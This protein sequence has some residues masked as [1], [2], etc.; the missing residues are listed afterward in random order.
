MTNGTEL[1][2]PASGAGNVA[3]TLFLP[4]AP[5][6]G[7]ALPV[8]FLVP[9]GGMSRRYF[10]IQLE[11]GGEAGYS[12]ARW[13]SQRGFAVVTMDYPGAGDS[14]LEVDGKPPPRAEVEAGVAEAVRAVLAGLKAGDL[15]PDFPPVEKLIAIGAGHSVGGH[16]IVGTQAAHRVFDGIA[17]LGASMTWTHLRLREGKHY[18]HRGQWELRDLL[19]LTGDVDWTA[20][21]H[22][23]DVPQAVIDADRARQPLAQWRT[24]NVPMFAGELVEPYATARQAANVRVPV[25]LLY[26]QQ[27]VTTEP[28]DDV[29]TFRSAPSVAMA[30]IPGMGHSHNL[31]NSREVLWRRLELFA[32]EVGAMLF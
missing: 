16:V 5:Q 15:A 27:D 1:Q 6:T 7:E 8:L 28:L 19:S 29:A 10:D 23:P 24:R 14:T 17:P 4:Q 22:W 2:L 31:A 32:G 26:G 18:P 9:G 11:G 13:F 3:A 20:N 30:V 25:L 12:Q 21:D